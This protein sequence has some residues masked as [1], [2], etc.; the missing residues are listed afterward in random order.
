M[1]PQLDFGEYFW[2]FVEK[3]HRFKNKGVPLKTCRIYLKT[4]FNAVIEQNPDLEIGNGLSRMLVD[5][6]P[7]TNEVLA[8]D[9]YGNPIFITDPQ[10]AFNK[11][12]SLEHYEG[13]KV[14]CYLKT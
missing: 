6:Q 13:K 4:F 1:N 5:S 14:P 12:P 10:P 7:S 8:A 3:L 9:I 2:T 11:Y